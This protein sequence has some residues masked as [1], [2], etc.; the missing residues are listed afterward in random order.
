MIPSIFPPK[1]TYLVND[2]EVIAVDL[3]ARRCPRADVRS[4]QA[5]NLANSHRDFAKTTASNHVLVYMFGQNIVNTDGEDWR[6]ER[7]IVAPSFSEVRPC[8]TSA[9]LRAEI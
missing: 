3:A 8:N 7:K 9:G 6:R 4:V 1:L 5:F 2:P